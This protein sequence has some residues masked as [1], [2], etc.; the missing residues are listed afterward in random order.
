MNNSYQRDQNEEIENLRNLIRNFGNKDLKAEE[1]IK[2]LYA[3]YEKLEQQRGSI[4]Q[5]QQQSANEY[6]RLCI[7][8]HLFLYKDILGNSGNF[9]AIQDPGEGDVYFGGINCKTMRDKFS[10][11][12]PEFIEIE[13]KES[14]NILFDNQYQPA[15]NSIRFYAEFVAIH[16]FY[17]ANGRIGRYITDA[18]LQFHNCY[19]DWNSLNLRHGKFLRKLNFCHSVREKHKIFKSCVNPNEDCSRENARWEKIREKY[20]SYL[21]SF[22]SQYVKSIDQLEANDQT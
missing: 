19:V 4:F 3:R 5:E 8:I 14:F 20:I 15:E 16:P 6:F 10:G 18:F 2:T 11:T 17:D 1:A 21:Y 7:Q 22:W 12:K 9:R 13:L